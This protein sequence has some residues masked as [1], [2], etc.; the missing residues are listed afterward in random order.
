MEISSFAGDMLEHQLGT[1]PRVV[2]LIVAYL[3]IIF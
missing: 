1:L 3:H 2:S